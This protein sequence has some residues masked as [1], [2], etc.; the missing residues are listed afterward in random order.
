MFDDSLDSSPS[1]AIAT[2]EPLDQEWQPILHAT[3]QVVLYNPTSHALTVQRHTPPP[4]A[5]SLVSRTL[6][7]RRCPYCHRRMSNPHALNEDDDVPDTADIEELSDSDYDENPR[8]RASNYFQLLQVANESASVPPT[9]RSSSPV[10]D[11]PGPSSSFGTETPFRADS[12]AE[13]YF[14]AFFREECRLGMGANGSVFLCQVRTYDHTLL[15]IY[16]MHTCHLQ[17]VLDGNSLGSQL[18][19]IATQHNK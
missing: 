5:A 4:R 16:L 17:H 18:P 13:G 14:K 11:G 7:G 8:S 3:N 2:L 1:S 12:M 10:L 15:P 9:P 6:V 19:I